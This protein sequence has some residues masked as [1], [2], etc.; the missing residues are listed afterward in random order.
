[1][2]TVFRAAAAAFALSFLLAACS[3]NS[4]SSSRAVTAPSYVNGYVGAAAVMHAVIYGVPVDVQGQPAT[5]LSDSNEVSYLGDRAS[6]SATGYYSV[7]VNSDYIGGAMVFIVNAAD[8]SAAAAITRERCELVSGC[9]SGHAYGHWAEVAAD[10]RLTAAVGNVQDNTR[11]N[12]NWITHLA[13][14]HAY[15]SYYDDDTASSASP[16]AN[17]ADAAADGIFTAFTIERGNLTL[18]Q[19]LGLSDVVSIRPVAPSQLYRAEELASGL[20]EEGILYGALLAAGQALALEAGQTVPQWLATVVAQQRALQGQLY[21]NHGAGADTDFSLCRLYG[22]AESVLSANRQRQAADGVV[23]PAATT[24]V[25]ATLATR[26]A[27][28]CAA[29]K[30]ATAIQVSAAD[31]GNWA[32]RFSSAKLFLAD[33]NKRLV[34]YNGQYCEQY[35]AGT[36]ERN[37]CE[38]TYDVSF[39]D[40]AYVATTQT[41]YEGLEAIY[42]TAEPGLDQ[43]LR[44]LRDHA[45]NFIDCLH[46]QPGCDTAAYSAPEKTYQT[47][48]LQLS[49]QPVVV[50]GNEAATGTY[51]A[52]DIRITGT[53]T[54]AYTSALGQAETLSLT[55]KE[56]EISN[57]I[58][59]LVTEQAYLRLVY[60]EAQSGPPLTAVGDASGQLPVGYTEPLGFTFYFPEVEL[61]LGG[62][63]VSLYFSAKLIGVKPVLAS[64]LPPYRYNLTELGFG[65]SATSGSLGTVTENGETVDLNNIASMTLTASANNA[66]DYYSD[67]V[68]P[69]LRDYFRS[70]GGVVVAER[71]TGLF[72]YQLAQDQQVILRAPEG[73]AEVWGEADYFEIDVTGIGINR[74][75]L[76][77]SAGDQVL[78]KCSIASATDYPDTTEREMTKVC[79]SAEIVASDFTLLDDLVYADDGYVSLFSIPGHGVYAPE[80]PAQAS[81]QPQATVDGL[82]TARF[83]QG[84]SDLSAQIVHA[85]I[86]TSGAEAVRAPNAI[87]KLTL[88]RTSRDDWEAAISAG[89]DYDYL[90]GVLPAGKQA[91]SLYLSYLVR[92]QEGTQNNL[93][94][95]FFTEIG[96]LTV[97][98]GGVKLL[99]NE[100][101]ESVG[102]TLASRI[103]YE[104]GG[105][106]FP[107]G[108]VNRDEAL[109]QGGCDAIAYLT[110]R[111]ALVA[112][113]REERK[114][115]Y[116]ARF[117]DGGFM[118]LGG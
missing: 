74:F 111:N 114:G 71:V 85:L 28:Y 30:E 59:E 20:R 44:D 7:R 1:M 82:L 90:V 98:R 38:A 35:L 99:G 54:V 96:G 93:P 73:E 60:D 103:D 2:T 15:T 13:A 47:G 51:N 106:D 19:Q 67:T 18:S 12:I 36:T 110:F 92:E 53:Q 112:V 75:E 37:T 23:I 81:F 64:P 52:F 41:Y 39:V 43:A 62:Q 69:A 97:F 76:Y 78:R 68:W 116:V 10:Y 42:R 104:L 89:Y 9:G 87:V 6:S 117:S 108:V 33:L 32:D 84:I 101:G 115:V 17:S 3:G 94:T 66:A 95:R 57:A 91:Q 21:K 25:L 26:K 46:D 83:A 11:V 50:T 27:S 63:T 16:N 29:P 105:A 56:P 45:L 72:R 88:T 55:Y 48:D 8:S 80:F 109:M 107:C 100:A 14:D 70:T 24:S 58:G 79:T 65:L 61:P 86:D 40:P 4:S 22:A 5:S 102:L 49:L 77:S 31:V 34:N 118:I 113:I